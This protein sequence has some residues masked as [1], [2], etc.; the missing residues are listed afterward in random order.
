[1][2][3]NLNNIQKMIKRNTELAFLFLLIF[4][5]VMSTTFYNDKEKLINENYRDVINNIYFKKS[6]NHIFDNLDPR[7]KSIEHKILKGETFDRILS[8]YLVPNEEIIKIKK[9]I[10]KNYNLNN[11]KTNLIIQ[12]TLD[13]SDNKKITTFLFPE[14]RTK[15]IKLTRKHN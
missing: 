4:I 2:I 3:F 15:K 5:T 8:N 13:E 10:G 6:I 14:S 7:Y 11:L 1:M 12:F 9:K